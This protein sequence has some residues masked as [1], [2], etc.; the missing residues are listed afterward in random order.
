MNEQ[1]Q[2]PKKGMS[3]GVKL[4]LGC[5]VIIFLIIGCFVIVSVAGIAG[6]S[7]VANDIDKETKASEDKE[8]E[9]FDNP[10]KLN[11]AVTVKDVQWTVTEGKKLGTTLKS[12]YGEF[13]TDCIA[14]SGQFIQV[15]VKIKNNSKE[16]LSTVNL[17]LYDSNKN[18]YYR[19]TEVGEC[20]EDEIFILDNIN[21]G[22]EKTFTAIYEVPK[23]ASGFRL[24]VGD[25]EFFDDE[26]QYVSL[27][28]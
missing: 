27:G 26:H 11:E 1:N 12:K 19:S 17:N 4:L 9:A 21:P 2:T 25:L 16:M 7:K 24:K 5:G 14:N 3:T 28:F 23:E 20:I 6:V 8:K 15:K 10:S 18:E 22:I 13:G